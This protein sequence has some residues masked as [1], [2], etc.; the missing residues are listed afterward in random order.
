MKNKLLPNLTA[1]LDSIDF[2]S[3]LQLLESQRA[4]GTVWIGGAWLRL[5]NGVVVKGSGDFGE[6]DECALAT[7]ETMLESHGVL[8]FRSVPG[9]PTG[10][11][12]IAPTALLLEAARLRDEQDGEAVRS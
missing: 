1:K 8:A 10:P 9:T 5:S 11:I 4:S 3:L 2:A 12:A 7:V 6:P